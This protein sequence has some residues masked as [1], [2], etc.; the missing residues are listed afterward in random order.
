M[1]ANTSPPV[2][3]GTVLVT[4]ASA[5]IGRELARQLAPRARTLVLL[6]RRAGH[7]EALRADLLAQHPQLQVV[8]LPADLSDEGDVQRV[9]TEAQEQAGLSTC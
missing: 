6:A 5:G 9:L 8:A 2:D 3:G 7:L 1:T 4:G